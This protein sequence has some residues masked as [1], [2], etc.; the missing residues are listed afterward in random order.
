[1]QLL[2]TG[3]LVAFLYFSRGMIESVKKEKKAREKLEGTYKKIDRYVED[4][5]KINDVV[6]P[7]CELPCVDLRGVGWLRLAAG[8]SRWILSYALKPFIDSAG[9]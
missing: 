2:K 3:I 7:L 9:F 8:S 6:I 5:K 4:L 1:M